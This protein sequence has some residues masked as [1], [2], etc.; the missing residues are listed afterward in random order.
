L[1]IV[2]FCIEVFKV[3]SEELPDFAGQRHELEIAA[4]LK[5]QGKAEAASEVSQAVSPEA[6]SAS[7]SSAMAPLVSAQTLELIDLAKIT[8]E[9]K[10]QLLKDHLSAVL[11][12]NKQLQLTLN[13]I[14]DM[15]MIVLNDSE[16]QEVVDFVRQVNAEEPFRS[17][18]VMRLLAF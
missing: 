5:L 11:L 1:R 15:L 14:R 9:H 8:A 6:I 4:I 2:N 17:W 12:E 18:G 13:I 16:H 3:L 10:E 7:I